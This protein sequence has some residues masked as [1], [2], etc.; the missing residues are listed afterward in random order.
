MFH[1]TPPPKRPIQKSNSMRTAP[2]A[3][4]EPMSTTSLAF[5]FSDDSDREN[6][7][8][9]EKVHNR[10]FFKSLM[11]MIAESNN[12]QTDGDGK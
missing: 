10:M 2:L 5:N 8:P 11:S 6:S 9:F 7:L 4:P 3:T 1:L 12:G